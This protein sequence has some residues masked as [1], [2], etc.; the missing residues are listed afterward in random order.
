MKKMIIIM[1]VL[2]STNSFSNGFLL[3]MMLGSSHSNNINTIKINPTKEAKLFKVYKGFK[4]AFFT[5]ELRCEDET[6]INIGIIEKL[7][8][9]K[10]GPHTLVHIETMNGD[11]YW[12]CDDYNTFM[13]SLKKK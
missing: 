3:G 10:Y 12:L 5:K 4:I 7:Y 2:F 1:F 6:Y 13:N 11:T 9:D 8:P